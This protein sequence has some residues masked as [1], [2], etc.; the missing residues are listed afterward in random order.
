MPGLQHLFVDVVIGLANSHQAEIKKYIE[1]NPKATLHIQ[2]DNIAEIM[3]NA[4]IALGAGGTTTWERMSLGIPSIVVTTAENQVPFTKE[5]DLDG[6]I[7]WVGSSNQVDIQII[8]DVLLGA[9]HD[10]QRLHEQ[11][12]KCKKIVSMTGTKKISNLLLYGLSKE[13]LTIRYANKA[14]RK[15]YFYWANVNLGQEKLEEEEYQV[16]FDSYTEYI[17][18]VVESEFGVVGYV[19]FYR[20]D[21]YNITCL[22]NSLFHK[23]DL[24]K[25]IVSRVI[26]YIK[27]DKPIIDR[28]IKGDFAISKKVFNQLRFIDS[29]PYETTALG[30][31]KK[32][33]KQLSIVILSDSSTWMN[34]WIA[35]LLAGWLIDGHIVSWVSDTQNIPKGDLCFILSYENLV[36]VNVRNRNKNNLVVHASDLPKGKGWSPMSWQVL[37]GKNEIVVTLFEAEDDI[38]SGDIYLQDIMNL[39]GYELV[40]DLRRK[41]A[42]ITLNLCCDFVNHYPAVLQS[43][44]QQQGTSTFYP[45]RKTTDS[46]LDPNKTIGEQ[47]NLLRIVDNDKYPAYFKWNGQSYILKVEKLK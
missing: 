41:Q 25:C 29:D 13:Y 17:L 15:Q 22:L 20:R 33:S 16:Y 7:N 31:G 28:G 44:R 47:F 19:K 35:K 36:E 45:K 18:I 12:K 32:K 3:S 10:P 40:D 43:S 23:Y 4:D 8:Y 11:S 24:S 34:R 38:D 21:Q 6:Y 30:N 42:E 14:D 39:D 37:E 46:C 1:D 27:H 2:I 5:L 26:N 9:I